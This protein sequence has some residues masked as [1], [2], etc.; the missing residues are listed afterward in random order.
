MLDKYDV[1][2]KLLYSGIPIQREGDITVMEFVRT[3]VADPKTKAAFNRCRCHL[4]VLFLS[5]IVEL[6]GSRLNR[7]MITGSCHPL[8][9]KMRFP[10]E[11][12]TNEDWQTWATIWAAATTDTFQ[13]RQPLGE[14]KT[15]PHFDWPYIYDQDSH[16]LMWCER[17]GM[18]CIDV[19]IGLTTSPGTPVN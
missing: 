8:C 14:W 10:P 6:D 19:E 15:A 5:D 9:S 1:G 13:L 16:T 17:V 4:N 2:V 3:L 12:P 7:D 18:R 11:Y